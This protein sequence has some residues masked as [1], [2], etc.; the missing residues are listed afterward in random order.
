MLYDYCTRLFERV[1]FAGVK[2]VVPALC[3][4]KISKADLHLKKMHKLV[5]DI[6]TSFGLLMLITRSKPIKVRSGLGIAQYA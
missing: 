2:K 5:A 4:V 3:L 1:V 6:Q